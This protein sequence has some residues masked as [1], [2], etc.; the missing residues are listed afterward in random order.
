MKIDSIDI[1]IIELLQK[2]ARISIANIARNLGLSANAT[3]ARYK[4]IQKSGIIKKT[5]NPTFL[6]QY[7]FRKGQTYKMQIIIR[8]TTKQTERLVKLIKEFNLEH[9]QIEC[10]ETFGH[11]NILVWII[12]ENPIDLHLIKDKVQS[13]PGVLEVKACV[14][15]DHLDFYSQ[16]NLHHLGIREKNG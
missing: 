15:L 14:L 11:Y 10:L 1:K 16:I 4:K 8:S 5:F 7:A 2:N 13:Q 12:S 3:R 6:P 9:S